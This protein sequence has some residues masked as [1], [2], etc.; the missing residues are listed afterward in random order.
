MDELLQD[1]IAE[2]RETLEAVSSEI[3][4]WEAAPDDRARLDSIFRFVHTVKGSCGFLDLPRLQR[5]SHAAEDVLSQVR[6][7]ERTADAPLVSAVL[8]IIDRI[9]EIVEAIDAG[10]ALDDS[11]EDALIAGLAPGAGAIAPVVVASNGNQRAASRSVR[12]NVDLLDR[13][14]GGMSDM[15]LARNELARRLRDLP[16]EPGIEAALD[17]LSATVAEMR[18]T[19]TRTRMQKVES[20]FSALPRIVRDTA[21]ELGKS[22]ALS[23]EGSDVE[24]DR[25]MIEV[26]R[27]P[28]V[29]IIRNAIDHG[30]ETPAVRRAAGKRPTG[31]LYVAAR[32]AGNQIV[33]EVSDDGAGIDTDRIVAKLIAQGR[34]PAEL[35][36]LSERAK[37]ALIFEPGFTTKTDVSTISGRGVG[38]D[39][40]RDSVEQI[41]GRIDLQNQPGVG[42][43]LTVQV[44]LT[45]SILSTIIV[46]V[47]GHRFAIPRL[48]IEEIVSDRNATIRIDRI[49]DTSVAT[50]RERRLPVV[51]LGI[52]LGLV[53]RPGER[54]EPAM[55]VIANVGASSIAIEVDQVIDNEELVIKPAAPAVMAAGVY[56]GQ[57]LPDTGL[58]MLLLDCA[59]IAAVAGVRIGLRAEIEAEAEPEPADD[60]QAMLLVEDLDGATRLVPLA[61]VDRIETAR[62]DAVSDVAGHL[63]LTIDGEIYPLVAR[64]PI[65]ADAMFT[66]L[67]LR[68]G[69]SEVSMAI[70]KAD[71]IVTISDAITLATTPGPIAGATVIEG[72]AVEIIDAHWLFATHAG[73]REIG[74]R[75]RCIFAGEQSEWMNS[76]LRPLVETMGY[77]VDPSSFAADQASL[78][79]AL[80]IMVDGV[81]EDR[82]LRLRSNP[83]AAGDDSSIYRYDR[84]ALLAELARHQGR[85]A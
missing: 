10:A 62:G 58:P 12:L 7:G 15:V 27:D 19:V 73:P 9:G 28:L 37:C 45:L 43:T 47:G 5:L 80:D 65:A 22:V 2:T 56:A 6:S 52:I 50:V 72:H 33:L 23:I 53:R 57:T 46:E 83:S 71:D 13:M 35:R 54:E 17:R 3:V 11:G 59:G 67:R 79:V 4:A 36:G 42:L 30:I 25:E 70:R 76:F 14:M 84:P 63:R 38:M 77:R 26:M 16:G 21:A 34:D 60:Q 32:Q 85:A 8:A 74:D 29:H 82:L 1:F 64:S 49:G 39:I 31:R 69:A 24:L 18:D 41:G 55:L 40:V 48:A 61:I 81:A 44:P 51:D 78:V 20:L 66:V 68:D 75:P